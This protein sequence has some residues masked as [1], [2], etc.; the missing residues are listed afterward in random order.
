MAVICIVYLSTILIHGQS[1]TTIS[2]FLSERE[3]A[4]WKKKT[5]WEHHQVCVH[6]YIFLYTKMLITPCESKWGSW[7]L[8]ASNN[9]GVL[10]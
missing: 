5:G 9:L 10:E 6:M 2:R 7:R 3:H 1:Y 8:C 4:S